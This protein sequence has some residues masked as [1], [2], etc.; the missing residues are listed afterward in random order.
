MSQASAS[1]GRALLFILAFATAA[2]SPARADASFV[3]PRADILA[4]DRT[5]GLMPIKVDRIVPHAEEMV[6]QLEPIIIE[7]LRSGGFTVVPPG[8]MRE[9]RARGVATLGGLYDPM[10]GIASPDRLEALQEFSQHEYRL[11]H[12]VDAILVAEVMRRPAALNLGAAEWDGVSEQVSTE[13]AITA[14]LQHALGAAPTPREVRALSLAVK[15]VDVQG[16]TLYAGYG[17][18]L[19]LEYRALSGA[20]IPYDLSAA[21]PHFDLADPAVLSRALAVSLDPL[22]LGTTSVN[23]QS[24]RMPPPPQLPALTWK[25]LPCRYPRL[26]LAPLEIPRLKERYARLLHAKLSALGFEVAGDEDFEELWAAE[27]SAAN[28]FYDVLTGL[29]DTV[30]LSAAR[31]HVFAKLRERYH[32]SAIV[33]PSIVSRAAPYRFGYAKWDGISESVSGGGS[34][35]FNASIFNSNIGY[36]GELEALS[37]RI[38]IIDDANRV[39]FEGIGG[40]ELAQH[41]EHGSV[42]P[43]RE[44]TLFANAAKDSTAISAALQALTTSRRTDGR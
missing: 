40:I 27:R 30:K 34:V 11:R 24:F 33:V 12:P 35:L 1:H 22:A 14:L 15:L 18:L 43:V 29:P 5:I 42:A 3:I 44:D 26:A 38:Q 32:L 36:I 28:G 39:L 31:A 17:G 41:L 20:V 4:A 23:A 6:A 21:D 13:S 19:V 7:R 25:E 37:L 8:A 16:K 9:I 10:T 2:H